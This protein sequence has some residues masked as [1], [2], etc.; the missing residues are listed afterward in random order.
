M[1]NLI[2]AN[3]SLLAAVLLSTAPTDAE[4][5]FIQTAFHGW[6]PGNEDW[7]VDGYYQYDTTEG[8]LTTGGWVDSWRFLGGSTLFHATRWD[9]Q[10]VTGDTFTLSFGNDLTESP[11]IFCS[12]SG[13]DNPYDAFEMRSAFVY[14]AMFDC[15]GNMFSPHVTALAETNIPLSIGGTIRTG[16][17]SM[18]NFPLSG[19]AIRSLK[20]IPEPSTLSLLAIG[21]LTVGARKFK[22]PSQLEQNSARIN[23]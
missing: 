20:P 6:I 2:T 23:T 19:L 1:R 3:V 8:V 7:V 11:T 12:T 13:P 16:D 18:G 15:A 5:T 17:V 10:I 4:A 21:L 14:F 22:R 9:G